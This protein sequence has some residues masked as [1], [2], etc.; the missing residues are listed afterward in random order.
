MKFQTGVWRI[1]RELIPTNTHDLVE[2]FKNEPEPKLC[3]WNSDY[4][5]DFAPRI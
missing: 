5:R 4:R 1:G 3:P 2:I